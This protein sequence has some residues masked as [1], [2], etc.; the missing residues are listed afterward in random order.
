MAS[1]A[2]QLILRGLQLML[3]TTFTPND[4][5]AQGKHFMALQADIGPWFKDYAEE[6]AK[7]AVDIHL[8]LM[9]KIKEAT[10]D[11]STD[12]AGRI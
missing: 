5:A 11:D 3:R 8:E 1:S 10:V 12:A 6:I 2:E 9:E 7:P 4:P